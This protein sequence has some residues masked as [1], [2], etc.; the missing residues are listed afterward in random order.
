MCPVKKGLPIPQLPPEY[1]FATDYPEV[2]PGMHFRTRRATNAPRPN[3]AAALK[4]K[5]SRDPD[6][7][8]I[9]GVKPFFVLHG[10]FGD[11]D[12]VETVG[13]TPS[14][15][16]PNETED[17]R[18]KEANPDLYRTIM[19]EIQPPEEGGKGRAKV[20][21]IYTRDLGPV[22]RQCGVKPTKSFTRLVEWD[23][24]PPPAIPIEELRGK[25]SRF[26]SRM[27]FTN[28]AV[29]PPCDTNLPGRPGAS[30]LA[31]LLDSIH[32]MDVTKT[33]EKAGFG[34]MKKF[35]HGQIT[36]SEVFCSLNILAANLE[37]LNNL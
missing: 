33:M 16:I 17:K 18:I 25:K 22:L 3:L 26:L 35:G 27:A 31:R 11:W 10:H 12:C 8:Y 7:A 28:L 32:Y 19:D 36:L 34:F 6:K 1:L 2:T 37:I 9:E 4:R 29:E 5:L 14:V 30:P 15:L 23:P 13:D 24:V 21:D 20:P